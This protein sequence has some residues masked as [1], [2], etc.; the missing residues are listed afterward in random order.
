MTAMVATPHL[1]GWAQFGMV[2]CGLIA[3]SVL[4]MRAEDL[5]FMPSTATKKRIVIGL[6]LAAVLVL[7][8]SRVTHAFYEDTRAYCS[9]AFWDF[10]VCW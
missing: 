10:I 2:L 4:A 6:V 9:W 5:G 7:A 1:A 8:G 3:F